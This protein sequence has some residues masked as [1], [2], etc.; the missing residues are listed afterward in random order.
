MAADQLAAGARKLRPQ[1]FAADHFPEL[2]PGLCAVRA[3]SRRER[4]RAESARHRIRVRG[5][6]VY[7]PHAA[8]QPRR[9]RNPTMTAT[10]IGVLL[11]ILCGVIEGIAQLF[12]K[13]SALAPAGNRL[14]IGARALI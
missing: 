5:R 10:T 11:V 6:L 1:L 9:T 3:L 7:Q 8:R 13:K 14:S 12:F 4:R 2:D